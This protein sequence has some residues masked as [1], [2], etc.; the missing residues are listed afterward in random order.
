MESGSDMG[1][2]HKKGAG[3]RSPR[4]RVRSVALGLGLSIGICSAASGQAYLSGTHPYSPDYLAGSAW[5]RLELIDPGIAD[6]GPLGMQVR[7]LA[8]PLRQDSSFGL[9]YRAMA[10]DGSPMFARRD[11]GITAVFPRS[12][13]VGT[14]MGDIPLIPPDTRF[15][16]GEPGAATSFALGLDAIAPTRDPSGGLRLDGRI[17]QDEPRARETRNSNESVRVGTRALLER[18]VRRERAG[19]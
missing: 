7:V 3:R 15:I 10:P 16:I 5:D 14:P 11:G 13:Y 8:V 18:A 6:Q 9:L 12:A 17:P 1:I 2:D 4:P 19:G